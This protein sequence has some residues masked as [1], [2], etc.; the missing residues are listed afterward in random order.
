[1]GR[2][3]LGVGLS[4][5]LSAAI[6]SVR[7][8]VIVLRGGGQVQGKVVPDPDAKKGERVLVVLP[9]G[10]TPLAL[11]KDQ[12][13]EVHPRPGPLDEYAA[14][15]E[16][17]AATAQAEYDLGAWCEGH[18]LPDLAEVHYEAALL[19]DPDFADARVKLGHVE[20]DGRWLS[21]D[22]QR[23]EQGLV[24][25]KGRWVPED[26]K[27]RD[28]E[29]AQNSAGYASWVRRIKLLVQGVRSDD[30]AR[31]R[32]AEG[33]LLELRDPE[34]VG[35]LVKVLGS[36]ADDLRTLLAQVLGEIPGEAAARALV[37]QLLGESEDAVRDVVLERLKPREEPI[38]PKRLAR[39][40]RSSDVRVINRA[41]WALGRLDVYAAVPKLL[42]VLITSEERMVLVPPAGP[43][44]P[45][46]GYNPLIAY[47]GSSAAYMT[48]PVVGPGAVAYGAYVV[49]NTIGLDPFNGGAP[50]SAGNGLGYSGTVGADRGPQPALMTFTSRNVEVLAALNRLTGQDFE[51]DVPRWRSW[52][53]R[54][55]NPRPAPA[56]RV[57]QP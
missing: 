6:G 14:R 18:E 22:E 50:I 4:L 38:V 57:P 51:Y 45:N 55:F 9:K 31:R 40:L 48:G 15:R 24:L 35:P 39:A 23:K 47:N 10:K 27:A 43:T 8:D 37:D 44:Y 28:D 11:R 36:E 21:P 3:T 19:R 17:L 46:T 25:H 52:V 30:P 53:A 56:R 34:A 5:L 26:E 12:I 7:A 1:M 13:L 2:G 49:P 32:E 33:Q 20:R 42:D 29:Q 41:A 54:S 16:K